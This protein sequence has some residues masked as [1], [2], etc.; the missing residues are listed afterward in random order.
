MNLTDKIN[1]EDGV[2]VD[3]GGDC[4]YKKFNEEG[5]EIPYPKQDVYIK[6]MPE[7]TRTFPAQSREK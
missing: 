6:Q 1:L 2:G 4:P 3:G 7:T 5:I